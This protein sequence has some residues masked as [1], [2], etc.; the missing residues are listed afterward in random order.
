MICINFRMV[1]YCA[2]RRA[3]MVSCTSRT[4]LGPRL[5]R[6]VRMSSS[7]SVGRGGSCIYENL[8]TKAFVCQRGPRKTKL[9]L[10]DARQH[11][12]PIDQPAAV[13]AREHQHIGAGFGVL[14]PFH[15]VRHFPRVDGSGGIACE[16]DFGVVE[17]ALADHRLLDE[18][19]VALDTGLF[20]TTCDRQIRA[21]DHDVVVKALVQRR[22]YVLDWPRHPRVVHRAD[23]IAN[24]LFVHAAIVACYD[25]G[26]NRPSRRELLAMTAAAVA[27]RSLRALPL[28]R[29]KLGITT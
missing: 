17:R 19:D 5:Q 21:A 18:L 22:R 26:M 7:A 25:A 6:T 24:R 10:A 16:V 3:A 23:Q 9:I 28:E 12:A 15:F 14:L 1:V 29:I 13:D 11:G 20:P 2:G 4:V 8:T 27:A